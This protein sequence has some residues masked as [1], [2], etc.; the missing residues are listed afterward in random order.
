MSADT[1]MVFNHVLTGKAKDVQIMRQMSDRIET[2]QAQLAARPDPQAIARA[3]LEKAA[4]IVEDGDPTVWD[5][6][7]GNMVE[8]AVNE[9]AAAIRAL[10]NDDA[11]LAEIV[12][13]AK[14]NAE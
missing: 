14:G 6:F 12:G 1:E 5:A 9:T 10:A 4:Q 13:R 11:A 8:G 3:A 7:T 2:L